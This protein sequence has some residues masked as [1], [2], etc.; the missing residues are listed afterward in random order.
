MLVKEKCDLKNYS[1]FIPY[2]ITNNGFDTYTFGGKIDNIFKSHEKK[3]S[4]KPEATWMKRD[5]NLTG[6]TQFHSR[7]AY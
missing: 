4:K 2:L 3:K 1:L 6:K 5:S 7:G